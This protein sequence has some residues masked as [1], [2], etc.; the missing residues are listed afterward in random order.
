MDQDG[1]FSFWAPKGVHRLRLRQKRGPWY[2]ETLIRVQGALDCGER[3]LPVSTT[4]GLRAEDRLSRKTLFSYDCFHI[5]NELRMPKPDPETGVAQW[6]QSASES[7]KYFIHAPGYLPQVVALSSPNKS[8]KIDTVVSLIPGST[9]VCKVLDTRGKP[10]AN[11]IL[12]LDVQDK[13]NIHEAHA[14]WRERHFLNR[15]ERHT[16][17]DVNGV[18]VFPEIPPG[19]YRIFSVGFGSTRPYH[20]DTTSAP[21]LAFRLEPLEQKEICVHLE[22]LGELRVQCTQD[23]EPFPYASIGLIKLRESSPA[24]PSMSKIGCADA[25]GVFRLSALVPGKYLV[26]IRPYSPDDPSLPLDCCWSSRMVEIRPGIQEI[27]IP[28]QIEE[29]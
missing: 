1:R 10:A 24:R 13:N 21:L 26:G 29:H 6:D 19:D 20:R 25:S 8:N 28:C 12:K 9:I 16:M 17:S 27:S 15:T 2:S 4:V 22:K 5:E 18:A 3:S 14:A 11:V 7:H 23:G